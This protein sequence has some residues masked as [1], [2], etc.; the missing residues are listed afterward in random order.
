[1]PRV[2]RQIPSSVG[3]SRL[4]REPPSVRIAAS[5]IVTATLLI[6]VVGGVLMYL[7]DNDEYPNIWV[8][9]YVSS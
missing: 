8:G 4:L 1:M 6:T 9:M 2:A 3:C 7:L 5:V